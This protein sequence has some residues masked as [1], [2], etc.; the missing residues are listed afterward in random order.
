MFLFP[1]MMLVLYGAMYSNKP[2]PLFNGYGT[3]D[4]SVPGYIAA[5]VA[6]TAAF[7]NLPAELVIYRERGI[8]RRYQ[9]TPVKPGWVL[10]SQML[11]TLIITLLGSLLLVVVGKLLYHMYM[12]ADLLSVL[13]GFLLTCTSL[14]A[15]GFLIAS[16]ARRATTAR[17]V[18]MVIY[19]PMMFLSGGSFPRELMPEFLKRISDLIPLTYAVNL[20]KD[21][22]F[23]KGWN[24]TAVI[25]LLA[26]SLFGTLVSIWLFRWE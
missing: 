11:V 15:L 21:L 3:I 24:M 4:I 8:L 14:F 20:M 17:A 25:V 26:I 22:W 23:G 1:A 6:G 10:V 12:P 9:A 5:L 16:L 13:L 18:G 19:F 2:T 7:M